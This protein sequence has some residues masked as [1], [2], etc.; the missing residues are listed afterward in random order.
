MKEETG[1]SELLKHDWMHL[2]K[3]QLTAY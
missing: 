2:Q 3:E 1:M